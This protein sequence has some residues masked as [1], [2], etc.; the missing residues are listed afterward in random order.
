MISTFF[1]SFAFFG[2]IIFLP[3]WFQFVHGFSP[4]N[5]GLAALPL[6]VGLIVSSIASGLIVA[7][8]G[9]Y[10]WLMVGAI[11]VMGISTALMT[12]LTRDHA[13]DDRLVLDVPRRSRCGPDVRG[14]HDRRPERR[15]VPRARRR[16]HEPDLLPPDRRHGRAGDR[17]HDLRDHV[18]RASWAA[19][20]AA[21]V[22][23]RSSTASRRRARAAPSISTS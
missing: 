6:M 1:A 19:L 4:T 23:H 16:D 20:A 8:T 11:V 12:Q 5:S 21:G 7:R 10:K 2:A 15:A 3:R 17:R 18:Q 14:L 13:A 9:R 22:P